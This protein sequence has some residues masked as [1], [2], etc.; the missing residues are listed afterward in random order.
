[1]DPYL[2][3]IRDACMTS[4][5]SDPARI[6]IHVSP[7]TNGC[8]RCMKATQRQRATSHPRPLASCANLHHPGPSKGLYT[9]DFGALTSAGYAVPAF[10]GRLSAPARRRLKLWLTS[11]LT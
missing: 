2:R 7:C 3:D 5:E 4:V 6:A 11:G 9:P 1:M 10:P 8:F